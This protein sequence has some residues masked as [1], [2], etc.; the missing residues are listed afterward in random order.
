MHLRRG[1]IPY[2]DAQSP[3]ALCRGDRAGFA[4]KEPREAGGLARPCGLMPCE[5]VSRGGAGEH[6]YLAAFSPVKGPSRGS[7]GLESLVLGEIFCR[8]SW[9][10]AGRPVVPWFPLRRQ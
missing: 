6:Q 7:P 5:R 1:A 10:L 9:A 8:V 4:W 2:A 3:C